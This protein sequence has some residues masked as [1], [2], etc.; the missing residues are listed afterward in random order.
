M[1]RKAVEDSRRWR[2]SVMEVYFYGLFCFCLVVA[3]GLWKTLPTDCQK[4]AVKGKH[5]SSYKGCMCHYMD[6]FHED[7]RVLKAFYR[8]PQM[9]PTR[10]ETHVLHPNS[11]V[12]HCFTTH[13]SYRAERVKTF[14][15][16]IHTVCPHSTKHILHSMLDTY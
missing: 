9:K 7:P 15:Q 2:Y 4:S 8:R 3:G 10:T 11:T 5:N 6:H 12:K 13:F 14:N 16:M 1:Q